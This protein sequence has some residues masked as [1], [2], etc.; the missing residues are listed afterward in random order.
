MIEEV[1]RLI[2][3]GQYF[4]AQ[5]KAE[6]ACQ[7]EPDNL[8]A[9]QLCG[10][11]MSKA[12]AR[13]AAI[14]FLEPVLK[15]NPH[16]PE[17][18]GILGGVFKH[19][20]RM[21][22]DASF[23][24]KS[25]ETYLTNYK[26]TGSY[27]TG[28]NA[29]TMS[30]ILGRGKQA[31]EIAQEVVDSIQDPDDDY[32]LLAT[33]GEAYI[34][35]K[36]SDLAKEYFL[37]SSQVGKGQFGQLNSTYNQLNILQHYIMVP[38]QLLKLFEPPNVAVFAGHMIDH[39]D[40]RQPRFPNSIADQMKFAIANELRLNNIKI[41]YS[42]MA[43]GSD[44]LFAEA[45]IEA[46]GEMNFVLPFK[47]DDFLKTSVEFAGKEW[48][49]R[50][51]T[52]QTDH[53]IH[54]ITREDYNG[55][56]NLFQ[57]LGKVLIGAGIMR[58]LSFNAKPKLML[59]ASESDGDEK[60]GGTKSIRTIWPYNDTIITINP[61]IYMGPAAVAGHQ[62]KYQEVQASRTGEPGVLKSIKY[63]L[64]AT[65][66][67]D[68]MKEGVLGKVNSTIDNELKQFPG[69]RLSGNREEGIYA[70]YSKASYAMEFALRLFD[71]LS[72]FNLSEE[73]VRVALEAVPMAKSDA[74]EDVI[75][76]TSNLKSVA[77]MGM[78]F[79]TMQFATSLSAEQPE[80]FDYHRVGMVSDAGSN[81][82]IE[83][84]KIEKK[85]KTGL[86]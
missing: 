45:L 59:V 57:F 4:E 47:I 28:I 50:F 80:K 18:A 82:A 55:N 62:D 72:E 17:T 25:L 39:P 54:Y 51:Q 79:G 11:A 56:D 26:I 10:L 49:Q 84:F 66:D 46:G 75:N 41:G 30:Q 67:E 77:I 81:D 76:T 83:V 78:P 27:Y 65:L 85:I 40:R 7:L 34:L 9:K 20:F 86:S 16:D 23:A 1:K 52:L 73:G 64:L 44:I 5:N 8:V 32:W 12:G 22:A 36:N 15:T 29:A 68:L 53:K 74:I 6:E 33:L 70:I 69:P 31:R 14:S 58:G 42:S 2:D 37:K 21:T 13:Q 24:A 38:E 3:V 43:C 63:I 48:V 60:L 61:D 71:I 19:H 35:L